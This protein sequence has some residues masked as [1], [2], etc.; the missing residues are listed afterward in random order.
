MTK[1][2]AASALMGVV[3]GGLLS[4]QQTL[5]DRAKVEDQNQIWTSGYEPGTL[6][7]LVQQ[8]DTIVVGHIQ[9]GRP[10]LLPDDNGVVTHY[11]VEIDR[12]VRRT[13]SP[14]LVR[15][16]V[17]QVR[18]RGGTMELEGHIV[19]AIEMGFDQFAALESYLFFLAQRKNS[20]TDKDREYYEVSYGPQGA[21]RLDT[22]TNTVRPMQDLF[23]RWP[24]DKP[25]PLATV[26]DEVRRI[27]SLN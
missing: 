7:M 11:Y 26:I 9:F 15:G 23:G 10:A 13:K 6:E 22:S 5:R 1:R 14:G 19:R 2:L 20:R 4:A 24:K 12:V 3:L 18:R 21:F 25:I 8:S 27:A 16:E 17:L